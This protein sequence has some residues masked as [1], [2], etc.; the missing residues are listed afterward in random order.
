MLPRQTT[1]RLAPPSILLRCTSPP[2]TPIL[3]QKAD[4]AACEGVLNGRLLC[5]CAGPGPEASAEQ[6]GSA[7]TP[8]TCGQTCCAFCRH[9]SEVEDAPREQRSQA[10]S[11][12]PGPIAE[13]FSAETL[14]SPSGRAVLFQL[15][16]ATRR[17]GYHVC[18]DAPAGNRAYAYLPGQDAQLR[19]RLVHIDRRKGLVLADRSATRLCPLTLAVG[20]SMVY[21]RSL[22]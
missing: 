13:T 21:H 6:L 15:L 5:S 10:L 4:V 22:R 2:T 12:L 11:R 7:R 20:K 9:I 8:A 17:S 3:H 16:V 18:M 14:G 19:E 1:A